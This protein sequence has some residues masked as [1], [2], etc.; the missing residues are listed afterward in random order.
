MPSRLLIGLVCLTLG[1]AR[2]ESG[3]LS[4]RCLPDPIRTDGWSTSPV[5]ASLEI[6][7]PPGFEPDG[8]VQYFHGGR[9]WRSGESEIEVAGGHWEEVSFRGYPS[10][11]RPDAYRECRT[12]IAGYEV[13]VARS[14]VHADVD[15]PLMP[16]GERAAIWFS[17]PRLNSPLGGVMVGVTAPTSEQREQLLRI[18]ASIRERGQ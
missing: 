13:F 11:P 7:I 1:C 2:A 6:A 10:E 12:R 17:D 4:R 16:G 14:R 9:R 15:F 8:R 18:V 5:A 3:G